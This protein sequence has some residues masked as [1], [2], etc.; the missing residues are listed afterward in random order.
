MLTAAIAM[1]VEDARWSASSSGNPA[2]IGTKTFDS[3]PAR[4]VSNTCGTAMAATKASVMATD[5]QYGKNEPLSDE[6]GQQIDDGK[7]A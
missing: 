2:N 3:G 4:M 7:A 6:C 5:A 1:I